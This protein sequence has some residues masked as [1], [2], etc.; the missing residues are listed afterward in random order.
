MLSKDKQVIKNPDSEFIDEVVEYVKSFFG[1][2]A[3][4]LRACIQCGTC[5]GGCPSGRRT[6]WRTR[7]I[8]RKVQMGLKKEALSEPELWDCTTCYTC[9]ERCIRAIPTTDIIRCLRNIAF[10]E[11]LGIQNAHVFVANL[12]GKFGHAV[13]VNDPTKAVRKKIG[14]SELPPTVHSYPDGLEEVKTLL[15]ETGF[16]DAVKKIEEIKAKEKEE[17]EKKKK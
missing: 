4:R 14:L 5:T 11:G 15:Q 16:I 7:V 10:R 9:Q 6:A 17:A 2:D 13:P 3:E 1:D 8:F 12:L